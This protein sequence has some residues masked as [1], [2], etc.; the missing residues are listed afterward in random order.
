MV[1]ACVCFFSVTH[2]ESGLSTRGALGVVDDISK[3][4][5]RVVIVGD[6]QVSLLSL[7]I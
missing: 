2:R 3:H 6:R 7:D 1:L 4:V 5:K